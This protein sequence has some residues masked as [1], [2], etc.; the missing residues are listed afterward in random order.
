M[1]TDVDHPELYPSTSRLYDAAT[2][3]LEAS[4]ADLVFTFTVPDFD[5][6]DLQRS[7]YAELNADLVKFMSSKRL[8]F[9]P[10]PSRLG[11]PIT[12]AEGT[13]TWHALC[14]QAFEWRMV[15]VGSKPRAGT[16]TMGYILSVA[17]FPWHSYTAAG[18][19][20]FRSGRVNP[21]TTNGIYYIIGA[22]FHVS[23]TH[24]H[25]CFQ[26]PTHG[27]LIGYPAGMTSAHRCFSLR[28][29]APLAPYYDANEPV[30][31]YPDCTSF[32]DLTQGADDGPSLRLHH[33]VNTPFMAQY[34]G[35]VCVHLHDRPS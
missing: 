6:P 27:P 8:R 32:S 31:C 20:A 16:Q 4:A 5:P 25:V 23:E 3:F 29:L 28:I 10:P 21:V 17:E 15:H 22:L 33:T 12:A 19:K 34:D 18:F 7:F 30:I 24:T 11:R 14:L 35:D 13:P 2:F 26:A 1:F 9:P